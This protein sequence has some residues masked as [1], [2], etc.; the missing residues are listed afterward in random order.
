MTLYRCNQRL[1]TADGVIHEV[2]DTVDLTG[3]EEQSAVRQAAVELAPDTP[4]PDLAQLQQQD[5]ELQAE[6]KRMEH[7]GGAPS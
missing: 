7:E 4:Q 2:G 6:I 1:Q 3:D 5:A